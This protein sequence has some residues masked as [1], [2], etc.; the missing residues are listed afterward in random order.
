MLKTTTL[1][2]LCALSGFAPTAHAS[3]FEFCDLEGR[4]ESVG[5]PK[6][7]A[8]T[9]TVTIVAAR[10]AREMGEE[11]Y[12]DCSEHLGESMDVA[13]ELPARAGTPANGDVLVFSRSSI[14]AFDHQGEFLGNQVGFEFIGLRKATPGAKEHP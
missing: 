7:E 12:T 8:T 6:D 1:L 3:W 9:H 11:S 4:I 5:A 10:R 13:I 2:A 14:D